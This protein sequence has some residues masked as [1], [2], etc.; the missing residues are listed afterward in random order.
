MVLSA[1]GDRVGKGDPVLEL[2]YRD[3]SRLDAALP[4]A[5]GAITIGD[6]PPVPRSLILGEVR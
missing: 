5:T 6:T 2:H 1:P 3:R 4:L